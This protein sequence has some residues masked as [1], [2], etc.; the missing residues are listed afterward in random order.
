MP[1]AY[2]DVPGVFGPV[3][4]PGRGPGFYP[5]NYRKTRAETNAER[6]KHE[7]SVAR[8][9]EKLSGKLALLKTLENN[10]NADPAEIHKVQRK[11]TKLRA[12]LTYKNAELNVQ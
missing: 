4:C 9:R 7:A 1:G 12:E 2:P 8:T 6:K 10:P 3:L 5:V 11:V